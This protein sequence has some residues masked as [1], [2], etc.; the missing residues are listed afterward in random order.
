MCSRCLGGASPPPTPHQQR[1]ARLTDGALQRRLRA[2]LHE[3]DAIAEGIGHVDPVVP[4]ERLVVLHGEPGCSDG[5][6]DAAHVVDDEGR[7]RLCRRAKVRVDTEVNLQI[8]ILE[9]AA[10][11]RCE[12]IRLRNLGDAEDPS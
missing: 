9:P 11:A 2:R 7:M 12:M 8:P 3:F 5:I 1:N 10:T 4:V 6:G